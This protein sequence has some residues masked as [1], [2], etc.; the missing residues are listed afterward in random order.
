MGIT[1]EDDDEDDDDDIGDPSICNIWKKGVRKSA[2]NVS[3]CTFSSPHKR[4]SERAQE[5]EAKREERGGDL[6]AL[7]FGEGLADKVA[8]DS[9]DVEKDAGRFHFK[10]DLLRLFAIGTL[11]VL[12]F[13]DE[14]C[15][16]K[17]TKRHG[18][19]KRRKRE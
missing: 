19:K 7:G 17:R 10:A 5:R 16:K 14:F 9:V 12:D 13:L 15:A 2:K 4:L 1:E 3:I 6:V 8:D 18:Q 11:L